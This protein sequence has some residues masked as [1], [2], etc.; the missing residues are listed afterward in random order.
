MRNKYVAANGMVSVVRLDGRRQRISAEIEFRYRFRGRSN[1]GDIRAYIQP[2]SFRSG[3]CCRHFKASRSSTSGSALK[4]SSL[5]TSSARPVMKF[6]A[7]TGTTDS[8]R[9]EF[10]LC[11][12][13]VS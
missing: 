2:C 10:R 7:P 9:Y 11:S 8:A 12:D 13:A 1:T 5:S 6:L 4:S 3:T